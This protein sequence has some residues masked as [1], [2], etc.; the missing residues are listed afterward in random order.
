MSEAPHFTP[1]QYIAAFRSYA[2]RISDAQRAMLKAHAEAA[3]QRLSVEQI[4]RAAGSRQPQATYAAYGRLGHALAKILDPDTRRLSTGAR[5]W[6]RYLGKDNRDPKTDAVLWTMHPAVT[7]AL[8]HLGWARRKPRRKSFETTEQCF[9][10]V[11]KIDRSPERVRRK[12]NYEWSCGKPVRR[13]SPIFVYVAKKG[14]CHEWITTT[15]AKP[16]PK[17]KYSCGV[18]LMSDINPPISIR[19]LRDSI[20]RKTWPGPHLNFRGYA[21]VAIPAAAAKIIRRLVTAPKDGIGDA[22]FPDEINGASFEG[23]SKTVVVNRY[24]RDSKARQR[25]IVHYGAHCAVCDLNFGERYGKAMAGF[26][27]VHHLKPLSEIRKTYRVD[28]IKDLR[29]V[30]PNCHAFIHS[31]SPAV[32][33]KSARARLTTPR[34]N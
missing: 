32:S 14:I 30:C 22:I 7:S 13:G 29:P 10:F 15:A 12:G 18:R 16:D 11:T 1:R 9:L 34:E 25:C 27:H 20:P 33:I 23:A 8:D 26:I 24:E 21:C 17:W 2:S 4:A 19:Q 31:R 5:I 6:T 28:P 3:G